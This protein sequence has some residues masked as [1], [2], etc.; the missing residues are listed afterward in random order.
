MPVGT[1]PDISYSVSALARHCYAPT[2][3]HILLVKRVLR[4][5]SGI[6]SS[7]LKY[8]R[9]GQTLSPRWIA[10]HVVADLVGCEDRRRLTTGYV[11][12][13]NRTPIAW[14]MKRQTIIALIS[15]ESEYIALSERGKHITWSRKLYWEVA[16]KETWSEDMRFDGS[17]VFIDRTAANSLATSKQISD[18]WKHIDLRTRHLR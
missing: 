1:R 2:K 15:A 9:F 8:P 13:I 6:E 5:F 7:G 3:R 16:N 12:T 14:G 10:V 4:Y 18:R 11:S 17:N